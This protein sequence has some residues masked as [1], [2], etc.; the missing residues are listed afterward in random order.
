MKINLFLG[1]NFLIFFFI[2][3]EKMEALK[4]RY[5]IITFSNIFCGKFCELKFYT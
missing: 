4:P 3:L 1:S 5:P 2:I